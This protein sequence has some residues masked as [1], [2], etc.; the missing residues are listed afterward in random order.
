MDVLE[1]IARKRDG[2]P[3]GAEQIDQL[4][5]SFARDQVPDYQMAAW[6][7]AVFLRGMNQL[8]TAALTESMLRSGQMLQWPADGRPVV[9]KHSTGGVGDKVSLVLAPL[10]ACCDVRVPMISGRGLGPTGGTLDKL[11]SIPRFRAELTCDELQRIT[12]ELGCVIA[13][14]SDQIAPADKRLYALRDVTATVASVPLITASIMSKKLA[15]GLD[16]LTLDVKCGSGAFMKTRDDAA[17]LAR[18]LVDTGCH[19]GVA[20]SALLTNMNQ[21]LGRAVGNAVEVDEAVACLEG[22]GPDDLWR[23]VLALG[24]DLLAAAG[25]ASSEQ[26]ESK[27]QEERQSGRA[28]ERFAAMIAAQGGDLDAPRQLAPA[29]ELESDCD[30]C[31]TA[32]DAEKIGRAVIDLRGGRRTKDDSLDHSSGLIMHV[33]VGS[34][35]ERGQPLLQILCGDDRRREQ[36]AERL[37]QAIAIQDRPSPSTALESLVYERIAPEST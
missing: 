13:G 7:M 16:A 6:A 28:R 11:E 30:G 23:L 5:Q 10:L 2:K 4:I 15:E 26:A 1:I 33:H 9:D 20:T 17:Q 22:Q 19:M 18:S 3:L 27:L 12:R 8:E 24:A 35:V 32:M 25:V 29:S 36:A 31:V 34:Q 21:P 37:R 14:A